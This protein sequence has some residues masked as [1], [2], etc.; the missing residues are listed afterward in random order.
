M[1]EN[2]MDVYDY[3]QVT[4]EERLCSQYIDG[5]EKFG[6]K[7]DENM[8]PEKS[9]GKVILHMKRSRHIVNKVE[10]TRLQKHYE[11]CMNEIN[12]LEDSKNSLPTIV[13]I[14]CGLIGCAF[15][16]GSVFA[17]TNIP[18]IIWL[19]VLLGIPGF[20][21]WGAAYFSYKVVKE[22]RIQT[23]TPLIEA[24]YDEAYEVC[25]KAYRLL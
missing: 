4:V 18:P 25:E 5:Y 17:V 13:S 23:V 21:F 11:S 2:R 12:T 3:Q 6:W 14:S 16:A 1:N 9:M 15:M 7:L 22:K 20:L 8:K 10:L 24:K 19:T